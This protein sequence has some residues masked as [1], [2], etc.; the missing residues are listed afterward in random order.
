MDRIYNNEILAACIVIAILRTGITDITL[1]TVCLT[2]VMDD[3]LRNKH[4]VGETFQSYAKRIVASADSKINNKYK[5][6]LI[7]FT[8]TIVI[9]SQNDA[10]EINGKDIILTDIGESIYSHNIIDIPSNRL[11]DILKA[12]PHLCNSI[13]KCDINEVFYKLNIEL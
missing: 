1:L 6:Y 8:N 10:V 3:K 4:V 11:K 7:L 9:L 5:D 13:V 12:I 2:L